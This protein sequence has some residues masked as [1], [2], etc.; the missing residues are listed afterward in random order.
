M[1]F[2]VIL[3]KILFLFVSSVEKK[4]G[5]SCRVINIKLFGCLNDQASYLFDGYTIFV[6]QTD[7]VKLLLR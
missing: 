1:I 4:Y 3:L 2:G 7:Q 5:F 6:D